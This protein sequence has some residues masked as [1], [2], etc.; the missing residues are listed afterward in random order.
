MVDFQASR[1]SLVT[2][3]RLSR[4]R[5]T[6]KLCRNN[7]EPNTLSVLT[8]VCEIHRFVLILSE[9]DT[10]VFVMWFPG[11][12]CQPCRNKSKAEIKILFEKWTQFQLFT[13]KFWATM[14]LRNYIF[15][16]SHL[17]I[18]CVC[19]SVLLLLSSPCVPLSVPSGRSLLISCTAL[20]TLASFITPARTWETSAEWYYISAGNEAHLPLEGFMWEGWIF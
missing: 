3:I 17:L 4:K 19:S 12:R 2:R 1:P 5:E 8:K 15:A 14:R 13:G 7:A 6:S 18:K 10:F 20:P 11:D 9:A 16:C